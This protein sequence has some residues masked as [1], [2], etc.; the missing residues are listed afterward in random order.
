MVFFPKL[1]YLGR[2]RA[3]SLAPED[4]VHPSSF[5]DKNTTGKPELELI[6]DRPLKFCKEVFVVKK[7]FY[8]NYPDM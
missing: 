8:F 1:R 6:F 4:F 2:A 3:K 5:T 7:R